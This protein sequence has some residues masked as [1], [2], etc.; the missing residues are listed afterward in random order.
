[1]CQGM[2]QGHDGARGHAAMV[3]GADAWHGLM[4]GASQGTVWH[5]QA[6]TCHGPQPS[7]CSGGF[8]LRGWIPC[9]FPPHHSFLHF[10]P[11]PLFSPLF[12]PGRDMAWPDP[13]LSE[14]SP[15]HPMAG[16]LGKHPRP[17]TP[18]PQGGKGIPHFP[19]PC[20]CF[21]AAAHPAGP[22]PAL[23]LLRLLPRLCCSTIN[24]DSATKNSSAL[25][26]G[27]SAIRAVLAPRT[28]RSPPQTPSQSSPHTPECSPIQ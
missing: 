17:P 10:L 28:P 6:S 24:K 27:C 22:D 21:P 3:L 25:T 26:G 4:P 11:S 18:Q 7:C 16:T 2:T 19:A 5:C 23:L 14:G 15:G 20:P 12:L 8:V 1:M 13:E 9:Y